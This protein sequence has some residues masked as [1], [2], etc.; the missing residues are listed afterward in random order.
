MARSS[1]TSMAM[2]IWHSW[3]FF[4]VVN[5]V[6]AWIAS[7][8]PEFFARG[9]DILPHKWELAMEYDGEYPPDE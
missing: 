9:I 7:K 6:K 8:S 3:N 1:I 2:F 4:E 5:D